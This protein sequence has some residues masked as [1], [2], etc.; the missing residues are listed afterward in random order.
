MLAKSSGEEGKLV[1]T[2]VRWLPSAEL[3]ARCPPCSSSGDINPAI[4]S[5]TFP[6]LIRIDWLVLAQADDINL[7][8]GM[9]RSDA[10]Y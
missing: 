7:V 5:P 3:R 10:R 6:R 2:T 4:L 8:A 9:L 1:I